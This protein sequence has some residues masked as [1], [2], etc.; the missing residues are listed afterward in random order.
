MKK[1]LRSRHY[2][3]YFNSIIALVLKL[4]VIKGYVALSVIFLSQMNAALLTGIKHKTPLS[5]QGPV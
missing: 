3:G 1:A 4:K 5:K 2:H